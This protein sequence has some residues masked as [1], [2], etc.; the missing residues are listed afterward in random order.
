LEAK[1][2]RTHARLSVGVD[3]DLTSGHNFYSARTRD[4]SVGGLFI[5]TPAGIP[6]GTPLTVD[7]KFLKSHVRLECEVMWALT[8]GDKTLGVGVRFVDLRP[9]ARKSIE[10]FMLLRE[11]LSCGVDEDEDDDEKD[12]KDKA[13]DLPKG[14]PPVPGK[15]APV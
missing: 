11:P 2:R 6:I 14:P 12:K 9:A 5:D 10:A 15:G 3:V 13:Q 7:L 1:D 4:I 8:D